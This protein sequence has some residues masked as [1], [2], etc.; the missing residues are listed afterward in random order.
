MKEVAKNRLLGEPRLAKR[1]DES[2]LGRGATATTPKFVKHP[3]FVVVLATNIKK[4]YRFAA[5]R[6]KFILYFM[7]K[8]QI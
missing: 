2:A 5:S 3:N 4:L 7:R 1:R 6:V 8:L